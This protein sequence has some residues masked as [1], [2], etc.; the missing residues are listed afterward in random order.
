MARGV[1]S[2]DKGDLA[3]EAVFEEELKDHLM[4]KVSAQPLHF[5]SPTH[6][7]SSADGDQRGLSRIARRL[8]N[9][10]LLVVAS[11]LLYRPEIHII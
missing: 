7:E 2:L 8:W 1:S 5:V 10:F 6:D 11:D 4:Q 3:I 9:S